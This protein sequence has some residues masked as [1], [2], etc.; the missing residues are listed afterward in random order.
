[1]AIGYLIGLDI[2]SRCNK[3]N[4]PM[5]IVFNADE[6]LAMAERIE[7][8]GAAFYRRAAQIHKGAGA[9]K[10]LTGLAEM[11]D[12]HKAAFASMRKTLAAEMKAGSAFDPYLEAEMY[13]NAMASAHGGEGA[14][15]AMK[16]L[17]G[18]ESLRDI[19]RT[20]IGLEEKSIVF[21]LGLRDLVPAKMGREK[22]NEIIDEEKSHIVT[23]AAELRKLA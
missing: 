10:F 5:S 16:A 22:V 3:G 17:T 6:V 4:M 23:L 12:S 9:K 18:R 7:A 21:Y 19:L 20:A 14:P 1:M 11:E 8:D 2:G 15:A 13:L